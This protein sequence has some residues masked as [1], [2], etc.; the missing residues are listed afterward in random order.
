[1]TGEAG[2]ALLF[3]GF[4]AAAAWRASEERRARL[5]HRWRV[6]RM[7]RRLKGL[8]AADVAARM[9]RARESWR[10]LEL[11]ASDRRWL[12]APCGT[13]AY[14]DRRPSALVALIARRR[15]RFWDGAMRAAGA[16]LVEDGRTTAAGWLDLVHEAQDNNRRHDR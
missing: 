13:S 4:Y 14:V 9:V 10:R 3:V 5:A 6:R 1:M 8:A 2:I 16:A 7:R 12:P 15:E 11:E